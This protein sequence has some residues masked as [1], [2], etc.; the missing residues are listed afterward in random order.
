MTG[1]VRSRLQA[2]PE[3]AVP[4]RGERPPSWGLRAGDTIAP[5]RTVVEALGGG[6]DVEVYLVWDDHLYALAAAK[7]LR[8]HRI[9]SATAWRHLRREGELLMRLAH[10]C[11]LRGYGLALEGKYPHLLMEYVEGRTLRSLVRRYGPLG[12]EQWLPF[13]AHLASTLA[14]LKNESLVHLD[15]KP[16]NVMVGLRPTLLDLGIA[17]TVAAAGELRQAIGTQSW[18]APEQCHP[19]DAASIGS[20]TDVW[21]LGATLHYALTGELPFPSR[22][23]GEPAPQLLL[24]PRPLPTHVPR[25]LAGILRQMLARAPTD[26]PTPEAIVAAVEGVLS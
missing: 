6:R 1:A 10:P 12:K 7:I 21:G 15:I 8:P 24:E 3:G 13:L 22:D 16:S 2:P 26:R 14:Y 18:M 23:P 17:R 5:G 11:L 20:A 4:A 19:V 9:Q 25:E